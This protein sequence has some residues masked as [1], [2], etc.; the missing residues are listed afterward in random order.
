VKLSAHDWGMIA[1]GGALVAVIAGIAY[2][3]S[4]DYPVPEVETEAQFRGFG[5]GIGGSLN[6]GTNLSLDPLIHHY[7]PGLDPEPDAQKLRTLPI[8]YPLVPGGNVSTVIHRGMDAMNNGS[9]DNCWRE[10][11]PSEVDI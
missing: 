11:P 10:F 6:A 9:P 3:G 1:V 8:R 2:Q 7:H 4:G 5:I